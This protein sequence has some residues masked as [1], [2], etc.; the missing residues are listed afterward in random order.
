MV[1][2]QAFR[3]LS[4]PKIELTTDDFA[5]MKINSLGI[6]IITAGLNSNVFGSSNAH[7]PLQE[8]TEYISQGISGYI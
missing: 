6:T 3:K 7:Y 8:F 5:N 2:K 1:R 4:W